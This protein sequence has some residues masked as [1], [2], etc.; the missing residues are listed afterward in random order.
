MKLCQLESHIKET[1]VKFEFGQNS[2]L[3][4][5]LSVPGFVKIAL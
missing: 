5:G 3:G 2:N 1:Q 4:N